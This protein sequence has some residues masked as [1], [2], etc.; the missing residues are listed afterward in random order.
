MESD[1]K[2]PLPDAT[3]TLQ[4]MLDERADNILSVKR[5]DLNKAIYRCLDCIPGAAKRTCT[6]FPVPFRIHKALVRPVKENPEFVDITLDSAD[7]LHF[8]LN[9]VCDDARERCRTAVT[10][11]F[12]EKVGRLSESDLPNP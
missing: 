9:A 3:S 5:N 7:L 6:A 8:L 11:A 2:T 10:E 4:K 1:P 12:M